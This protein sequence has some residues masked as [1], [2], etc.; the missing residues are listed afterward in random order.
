MVKEQIRNTAVIPSAVSVDD[1]YSSEKGREEVLGLGVKIVS[2]SGAKG[3]KLIGE[4]QWK[5]TEYR[6][7][8]SE[9][10]AIESLHFTL[11]DGFDF[12]EM[13]RRTRENVEAEM[14]EKVLAYNVC[15]MIRIRKQ[16]S[17]AATTLK[18]A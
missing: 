6:S 1:G 2:I 11:K 3:K 10:S 16:L 4:K 5:S 8:R 12:G 18:A 17:K 7:A 14:L 15:H 9:R 13:T